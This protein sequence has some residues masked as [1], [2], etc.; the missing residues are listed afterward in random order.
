MAMIA[1]LGHDGHSVLVVLHDLNMASHFDQV[2]LLCDG[3]IAAAGTPNDVLTTERLTATYGHPIDV[4]D[5]PTRHGR[6]MV[7]RIR[8]DPDQDDLA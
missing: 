6:L 1:M 7:P 8:T 4:V 2:V 5:H 3:G